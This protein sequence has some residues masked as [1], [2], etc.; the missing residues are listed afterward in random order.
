MGVDRLPCIGMMP[1]SHEEKIEQT[2]SSQ[3]GFCGMA[4][5]RWARRWCAT[6]TIAPLATSDPVMTWCMKT[7]PGDNGRGVMEKQPIV[8]T[9]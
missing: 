1:S 8:K 4:P 2:V 9:T 6:C 7:N 5:R 3:A